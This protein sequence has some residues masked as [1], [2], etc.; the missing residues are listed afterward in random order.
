MKKNKI[1]IYYLFKY[2]NFNKV[3]INIYLYLFNF[4]KNLKKVSKN[5]KK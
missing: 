1:E 4:Y 5:S 3:Q 2:F